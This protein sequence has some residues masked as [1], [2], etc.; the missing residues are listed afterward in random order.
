[1]KNSHLSCRIQQ[2]AREQE[3]GVDLAAAATAVGRKENVLQRGCGHSQFTSN[4]LLT[5]NSHAAV[6]SMQSVFNLHN[7]QPT[8]LLPVVHLNKKKETNNY[9]NNQMKNSK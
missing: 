1:M 6:V 2:M 4:V 5:L 8:T 7:S 3:S 9:Y